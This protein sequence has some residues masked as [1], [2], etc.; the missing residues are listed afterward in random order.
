[1]RFY[2]HIVLIGLLG[3][4]TTETIGQQT[5][6]FT[7][8]TFNYFAINPALAG[9]Q[10]CLKFKMGYR[11]QWLG[12][13]GAPQTGFGSVHARLKSKRRSIRDSYHGVGAYV[14]NDVIGYFGTTTLNLAYAYHF[15]MGRKVRASMGVF[16]GMQQFRSDASRILVTDYTDP[17]ITGSGN[18]FFVPYFTPGIFLNHD[19]WFAGLSIRQVV[20]NKWSKVIGVDARNRSHFSIIGGKRF[21]LT[22]KV[23]LIPSGLLKWTGV[24]APSLDLTLSA[25]FTSYLKMGLSWRNQDAL[26]VMAQ[27]KF[28]KFFSLGYAFDFTT[29]SLRT[30]SSNTHELI[31]GV[32]ACPHKS[33][34]TFLCPVFD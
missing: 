29:S 32:S 25:E 23:N 9:S 4:I 22:E 26:A 16:G 14:E 17:A 15:R 8:Y 6:Q 2:F 1:M 34:D 13:Q 21:K 3:I 28:A 11:L 27:V 20:R 12:L 7:Q 24:T 31:L 30:G 19:N 10:K 18:A 33:N 5:T